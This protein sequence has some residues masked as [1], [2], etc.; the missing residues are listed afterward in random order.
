MWSTSFYPFA[1]RCRSTRCRRSP[2]AGRFTKPLDATT[3]CRCI[4]HSAEAFR[5]KL[6]SELCD[7]NM[8]HKYM[9][10][11]TY[12]PSFWHYIWESTWQWIK[13]YPLFWTFFNAVCKQSHIVW[14]ILSHGWQH[15]QAY[16]GLLF[17]APCAPCA[18]SA[19]SSSRMVFLVKVVSSNGLPLAASWN[20]TSRR[21]SKASYEISTFFLKNSMTFS[22]IFR[23]VCWGT[24]Q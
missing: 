20:F 13:Y 7:M 11:C 15:L 6:R 16:E 18:R 24:G 17:F 21:M 3:A 14:E 4:F 23:V 1:R 8:A 10:S 5:N 22:L 9:Y 12:I 19:V 2:C